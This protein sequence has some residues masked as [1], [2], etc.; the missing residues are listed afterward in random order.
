MDNSK[1]D[2]I[3]EQYLKINPKGQI[4]SL[5]GSIL[6]QPLTDSLA[7]SL[8][9]AETHYPALLPAAHADLIRELL[10]RIHRI[11]GLSINNKKATPEMQKYN[12]SPVQEILARTDI[13][14]EYRKALQFKLR[15]YVSVAC[16]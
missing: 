1:F 13:S 16:S 12:P 15:L 7:I 4:P 3:T 5:T 14:P 9:L 10:D 6:S 11:S 8:Y 2:N